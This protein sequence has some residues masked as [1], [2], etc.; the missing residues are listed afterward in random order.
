MINIS[1]FIIGLLIG[2]S[3]SE[4]LIKRRA[5]MQNEIAREIIVNKALYSNYEQYKHNLN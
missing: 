5:T 1:V 2:F 4:W 3:I